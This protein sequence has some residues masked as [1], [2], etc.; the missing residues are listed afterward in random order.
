MDSFVNGV[1]YFLGGLA[2]FFVLCG[3]VLL[4][5]SVWYYT[6]PKGAPQ[7]DEGISGEQK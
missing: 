7:K 1:L 5:L 4:S 2:G 3:A 6:H